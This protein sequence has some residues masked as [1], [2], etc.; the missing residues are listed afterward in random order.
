MAA[1]VLI[2]ISGLNEI[3][4]VGAYQKEFESHSSLPICLKVNAVDGIRLPWHKTPL[5]Y[6]AVT[7]FCTK[8]VWIL[9]SQ[10]LPV[11]AGI[12]KALG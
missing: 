6:F 8:I 5:C 10:E 11:A 1:A 9:F 4:S 2:H 12:S 3:W 7:Q